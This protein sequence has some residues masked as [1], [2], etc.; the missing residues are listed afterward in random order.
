MIDT[1]L[2]LVPLYGL[3]LIAGVVWLSCLAVPL[4]SSMLV[5]AS[6]G[7]A[8][9][10]DLVL[11]QVVAVAFAGFALGD[12][13]AFGLA[14]W[15]G[16][17][18]LE[19]VKAGRRRAA[20][21]AR[22]QVLVDRWGVVAVLLARTIVSPMGPWTSYIG[23]ATGLRWLPFTAAAL[24]GAALWASGYAMLGYLFADQISTIAALIVNGAGLILAGAVASGAG[25]WLWKSWQ[26]RALQGS[27]AA[28]GGS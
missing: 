15:G 27:V 23:G 11:W 25:W 17:K 20:L 14:R 5:M 28:D 3:V 7:F 9:A 22:A 24:L 8:A 13:A 12:Q 18:L 19:L 16:P 1:L 2:A 26:A 6:G 4:P 10:G 21:I